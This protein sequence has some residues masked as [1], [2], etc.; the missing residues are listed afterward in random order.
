MEKAIEAVNSGNLVIM[1]GAGVSMDAPT[2][3]PSWFG[4]NDKVLDA[5]CQRIERYIEKPGWLAE[6]RQSVSF[7]RDKVG[8]FSPDYQAQIMAEECGEKYF[9]V[10]QALDSSQ[11]NV[12]HLA[13][14]KLAK[15]GKLKAVVTTNFDRL[16]EQAL[17][18]AG[19]E[20]DVFFD[21]KGYELLLE[22]PSEKLPIIKI[23]G[24]AEVALSM[25]D[26]LQQRLLGRGDALN[27]A[28]EKLLKENYW[29]YA[30]FS[31][32]DLDH[33]LNYLGLLAAAEASPGF[34]F[35]SYPGSELSYGASQLMEAYGEKAVQKEALLEAFFT[36]LLKEAKL[37]LPTLSKNSSKENIQLKIENWANSLH[38]FEAINIATG[39]FEAAGE[40]NAAFKLCH[41]TWK[42][43][44]LADDCK[45]PHYARYQLNYGKLCLDAGEL[46][47]E[48]TPQ[49]L[50]RPVVFFPEALA[51]FALFNLWLGQYEQF[52]IH[53]QAA[54]PKLE[55]TPEKLADAHLIMMRYCD[56]YCHWKLG[57][58]MA[59]DT[60]EAMEKAG[61]QPR[62]AKALA[63]ATL[64]AGRLQDLEQAKE[65]AELG[66]EI[67]QRLGDEKT[68]ALLQMNLGQVLRD[69]EPKLAWLEFGRARKLMYKNHMRTLIPGLEIEMGATAAALEFY[70][71]SN[72]LFRKVDSEIDDFPVWLPR[73]SMTL[74][75][76]HLNGNNLDDA[77]RH[78][79]NGLEY[80]IKL[81]NKIAAE[82]CKHALEQL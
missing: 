37:D 72:D 51:N 32:A 8:V 46:T 55:E 35:L 3:L 16:V 30:G 1:A 13:I 6:I 57:L 47:Y 80:A 82:L 23:H 77:R 44:R 4:F 81:E 68:L 12:T 61:H 62:L 78:L 54:L 63:M 64:F 21:Q 69:T 10:L 45:G 76:V 14:A 24:T 34:T 15:A 53:M 79:R 59:L 17:E 58:S 49:N 28:L 48:E 52:I 31:A 20:F 19:V 43:W 60:V 39:L 33:D 27:S 5:L 38:P 9:E 73:F 74:A 66:M 65:Y 71:E 75:D 2:S 18:A 29:L 42:T 7:R 67:A 56:I 41:K 26:T 40:E 50:L 25:V 11:T 36:N 22:K 70:D